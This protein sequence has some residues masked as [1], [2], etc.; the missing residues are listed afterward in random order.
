MQRTM[1]TELFPQLRSITSHHEAL[2]YVEQRLTRLAEQNKLR[3][4]DL[5]NPP[6]DGRAHFYV[7]IVLTGASYENNRLAYG[8]N[9]VNPTLKNHKVKLRSIYK[10]QDKD[11]V[12]PVRYKSGHRISGAVS[13]GGHTDGGD[14]SW[15]VPTHDG[16]YRYPFG[17]D[18][19]EGELDVPTAWVI[20][21][22]CGENCIACPPKVRS[23]QWRVRE[24]PIE[25]EEPKKPKK[26]RRTK[27]EMDAA[28]AADAPPEEATAT[29]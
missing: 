9:D 20:L 10:P 19:I 5:F 14:N 21:S 27:A 13:V 6:N 16:V 18:V 29:P 1:T 26:K 17:Q 8:A 15:S 11:C 7:G 3:L 12:Q 24:M 22:Q 28:R 4:T 2:V 23:T 25:V